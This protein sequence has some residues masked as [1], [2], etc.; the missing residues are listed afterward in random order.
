MAGSVLYL[1]EPLVLAPAI[2][3][4]G[5]VFY[6][7]IQWMQGYEGDNM[8]IIRLRKIQVFSGLMIL[9][10]A[11]LMISNRWVYD[12]YT[13]SK[14]DIYNMWIAVLLAAAILQFYTILKIDKE[15]QR[16]EKK[17]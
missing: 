10:A 9:F 7:I 2:F 5:A 15:L 13:F 6:V 4:A 14:L 3:S 12:I 1:F 17:M 16:E 8:R 11:A